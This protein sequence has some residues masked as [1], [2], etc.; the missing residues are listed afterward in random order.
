MP[1]RN[2]LIL[3]LS[4]VAVVAAGL[5]GSFRVSYPFGPRTCFLPCMNNALQLYA[6]ANGGA[7]PDGTT[8]YAAL[9]KLYPEFMPNPDLLAGISG[10][11]K[12]TVT[13]L[14]T[15][16]SLSSDDCS[17]MYLP[18]LKSSD[19][20]DTILIYERRTGLYVN[21]FRKKGRAVGF[22]DGSAHQMNE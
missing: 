3:F 17:W 12:A 18:G 1:R 20:P 5:Y 15:N 6:D 14:H 9:Q 11:I 16:G 4:L 22:V 19:P 10:D 13:I 21:G 7:F 2:R 8:P